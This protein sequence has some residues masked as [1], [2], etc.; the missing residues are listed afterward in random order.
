ME[1]QANPATSQF[2]ANLATIMSGTP[3]FRNLDVHSVLTNP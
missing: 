1:Q 2:S 3:R